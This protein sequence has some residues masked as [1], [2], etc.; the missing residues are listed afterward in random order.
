M[1]TVSNI[2]YDYQ[3]AGLKVGSIVKVIKG[4]N[5]RLTNGSTFVVEDLWKDNWNM[6]FKI[7]VRGRWYD[8]KRFFFSTPLNSFKNTRFSS[9]LKKWEL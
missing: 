7:K 6:T 2:S 1:S 3:P 4:G 5:T 8:S 9:F